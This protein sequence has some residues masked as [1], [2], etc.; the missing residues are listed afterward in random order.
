M[1]Q[2][3]ETLVWELRFL[4]DLFVVLDDRTF[5]KILTEHC[6][7]DEI[8]WIAPYKYSFP[9]R[10]THFLRMEPLPAADFRDLVLFG[11]DTLLS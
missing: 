7:E 6:G 4:Q 10:L 9:L 2:I 11:I 8:K 1:P 3:V 5:N